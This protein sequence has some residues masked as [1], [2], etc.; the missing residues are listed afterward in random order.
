MKKAKPF[1]ENLYKKWMD[2]PWLLLKLSL[3]SVLLGLIFFVNT[4]MKICGNGKKI[5][6]VRKK[7][8]NYVAIELKIANLQNVRFLPVF[9]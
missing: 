5:D 8:G 6:Y 9:G 3:F 7:S 2:Q 4:Q 1:G